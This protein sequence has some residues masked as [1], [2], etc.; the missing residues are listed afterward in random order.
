MAGST[1]PGRAVQIDDVL[2]DRYELTGLVGTGG[3]STVYCAKDR[4]LDR[5]V[6]LKLLHD[7]YA[8]DH[9]YVERFKREARSVARLSHPNIVTVI[10]R[11]EDGDKQF[12]VFEF[13]DGENLKQLIED[14]GAL[15]IR[16]ALEIAIACADALA[17]AHA[18]GL[19]HRD[20]KP[21]NI[22]ID[23]EGRIRV[24]DFGI[25]RS[26]EVEAGVTQTGTVMGTSSY[27]SPEQARGQTVTPASD[28][29]SLGV[30]VWELLTGEVPFTGDNFV[31]VALQHINEP[32]PSLLE[33]RPDAPPRLALAVE[34]A[35]A[36]EPE[37]RFPTMAA[38]AEELRRCLQDLDQPADAQD[39]LVGLP[40]PT[41]A[42]GPAPAP[43]RTQTRLGAN[44]WPL[45]LALVGLLAVIAIVVGLLSLGGSGGKGSHSATGGSSSA[46]AAV[47][48]RAA[49]NYDPDGNPDSHAD[50]A[51]A[52]TDGD[53]STY[54][55]TQIYATPQFGG[56][57]HGLGL[58]LDAGGSHKLTQITVDS[59]TP[60]F[61][62]QI[63]SGDSAGGPFSPDSSTQTV[64]GS[65]TFQLEG[66]STR[67]YVV[68]ITQLP[69]GG[70]A[71]ISEV[72]AKG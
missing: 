14:S 71:E 53:S 19:V 5:R 12:I 66:R 4:L 51:S 30:V 44:R 72:S 8:D 46:G 21:Q 39:T 58:V 38:F 10:D 9:E 37:A 36:K 28:I 47:T 52:A 22:L 16:R 27:L 68:W 15:G 11:G 7:H 34:H 3:M 65:T 33:K 49:G 69:P 29:Y 23:D 13:V 63:Q 6:A 31:A 2:A 40:A 50:T 62:A 25:A 59:P 48:L 54:W 20:V 43:G 55:Y 64:S 1:S 35:L 45:A 17:F 24:T 26:L 61:Q 42:P 18:N 70:K 67:Y 57:K 56:L 41:P 60:G 32:P